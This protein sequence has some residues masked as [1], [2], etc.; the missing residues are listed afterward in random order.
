LAEFFLRFDQLTPEQRGRDVSVTRPNREDRGLAQV[1]LTPIRA[2]DES[3]EEFERRKSYLDPET[4]MEY[5][6]NDIETGDTLHFIGPPPQRP[7]LCLQGRA[8][9]GS[10]VYDVQTGYVR[11]LKD[12]WRINSESQPM[13]GTIYKVLHDAKVRH[14]ATVVA[15]GDVSSPNTASCGTEAQGNFHVTQ[16]DKYSTCNESWC[17]LKPLMQSYRHYRIVLDTVGR[18]LSS[19]ESSKELLNAVL[20]AMIG[21]CSVSNAQ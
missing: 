2:A 3:E 12:T 1:A 11:Y 21:S 14:I 10:P 8:S 17:K 4:F 16:T 13:E 9:R 19:F 7:L 6:V 5:L 15:H 20:D 18:D